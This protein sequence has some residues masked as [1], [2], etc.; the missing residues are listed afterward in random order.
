MDPIAPDTVETVSRSRRA[1]LG[2]LIAT[3]AA[4]AVAGRANAADATTD[5]TVASDDSMAPRM[6]TMAGAAP[7]TTAPPARSTADKAA[8]NNAIA[9]EAD[10]VATYAA[11]ESATSGDDLAAVTLIKNHHTAYVQAISGYL[12][13]D[14][15]VPAGNASAVPLS[16]FAAAAPALAALEA[17]A[18]SAHIETLRGLQG[19]DAA[20]L[21]A[22]II[23]VGARHQAALGVAASGDI[24]WV[25]K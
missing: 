2:G 13:R 4:V 23:T 10:L 22:S 3:G 24:Q 8:L 9:L 17:A 7:T 1:L 12:G 5:T 14:S 20:N 18:V 21:V 19:L 11:V 15:V 6:A 16:N 25:A